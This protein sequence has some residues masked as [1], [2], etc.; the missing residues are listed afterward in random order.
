ME[1][2][3]SCI[4]KKI[5]LFFQL[6]LL[7]WIWETDCYVIL[8]MSPICA[9]PNNPRDIEHTRI[10]QN[11]Q[12]A[13]IQMRFV[14]Y[15]SLYFIAIAILDW[16][17]RYKI[18]SKL[19]QMRP[20]CGDDVQQIPH[21]IPPCKLTYVAREGSAVKH[22]CCSS[23]GLSLVLS[24]HIRQLTTT[25]L[26]PESL[27]LS[28]GLWVTAYRCTYMHI[29]NSKIKINKKRLPRKE[30][31]SG[32]ARNWPYKVK[33]WKMRSSRSGFCHTKST[34]ICRTMTA[35]VGCECMFRTALTTDLTIYHLWV[36]HGLRTGFEI[37]FIIN[38]YIAISP[39]KN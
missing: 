16:E 27:A 9:P 26:A 13:D 37:L 38:T 29:I 5:I 23:R 33:I 25:T 34:G 36:K 11:K 2:K 19:E 39:N 21:V 1:R 24:T 18:I 35:L 12:V 8:T 32:D 4:P 15:N 14:I 20:R 3:V 28:S 6:N 17:C 31:H 7:I 22:N 10:I 30:N